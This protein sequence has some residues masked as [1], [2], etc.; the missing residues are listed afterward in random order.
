MLIFNICIIYDLCCR[1]L[2]VINVHETER[3]RLELR[4]L[5]FRPDQFA[6]LPAAL[7]GIKLSDED[8]TFT[9]INKCGEPYTTQKK[10][11]AINRILN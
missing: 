7:P 5:C 10:R 9:A 11:A 2:R 1:V 6:S 4:A 8:Y 3:K